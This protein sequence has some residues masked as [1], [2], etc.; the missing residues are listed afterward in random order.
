M[1]MAAKP[2]CVDKLLMRSQASSPTTILK[3]KIGA[4]ISPIVSV[5]LFFKNRFN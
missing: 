1:K 2:V 5:I 4:G 3:L